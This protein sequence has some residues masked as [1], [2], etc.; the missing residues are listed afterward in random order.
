[1]LTAWNMTTYGVSARLTSLDE[2]ASLYSFE[3]ESG[4]IC[5][6]YEDGIDIPSAEIVI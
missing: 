2:D 5:A 4:A 1:M 3:E 6:V